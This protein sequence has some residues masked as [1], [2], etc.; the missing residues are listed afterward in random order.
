MFATL[1]VLTGRGFSA[2]LGPETTHPQV[3][4]ILELALRVNRYQIWEP[5]DPG[6]PLSHDTGSV[7]CDH[8]RFFV[9]GI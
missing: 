5:R 7:S 9:N 6:S 2:L 1:A 8:I 3:S 4:S